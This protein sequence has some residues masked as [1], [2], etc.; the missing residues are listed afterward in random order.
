MKKI[1]TKITLK[2]LETRAVAQEKAKAL[3]LRFMDTRGSIS[4]YAIQI[5]I[6]VV[7]GAL[8]LVAL[9]A[10]FNNI[11]IPSTESKVTSMFGMA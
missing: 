3:K 1:N 10:L 6:G 11:I 9:I 2:A 7:V 4:E 8:L 5:I